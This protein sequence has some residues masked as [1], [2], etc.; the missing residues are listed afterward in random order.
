M[1]SYLFSIIP[2]FYLFVENYKEV[3][4]S[5]TICFSLGIL[6]L[7]FFCKK[8]L[9]L[10]IQNKDFINLGLSFFWICFW[11]SFSLAYE[12]FIRV[13]GFLPDIIKSYRFFVLFLG[14]VFSVVL[15]LLFIQK[16][17]NY[18]STLS[19][20]LNVFSVVIL[21]LIG[22]SFIYSIVNSK[23]QVS[24][25]QVNQHDAN[26]QFPNIY[27]IL[28]DAYAN[29]DTLRNLYKFDNS[30][31][32]NKL[33]QKGFMHFPNSLSLYGGTVWSVTSMLNYGKHYGNICQNNVVSELKNNAVWKSFKAYGFDIHLFSQT[34]SFK[35][36]PNCIIF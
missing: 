1:H 34:I 18:W 10:F 4:F 6:L 30:E 8:T 3:C 31:F 13:V 9:S 19:K 12:I 25:I 36:F 29:E 27:H 2:V 32:Y 16:I 21:N 20:V 35:R 5:H 28:L 7:T 22:F 26:K 24:A 17:K 15:F 14:V 23:T 11:Y 33:K